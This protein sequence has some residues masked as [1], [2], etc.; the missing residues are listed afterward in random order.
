M[1][2]QLTL[3]ALLSSLMVLGFVLASVPAP[4]GVALAAGSAP[5]FQASAAR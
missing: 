5:L 4:T 2:R 1:S 3:S